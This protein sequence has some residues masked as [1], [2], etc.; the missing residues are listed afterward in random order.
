[1][2][3]ARHILD[4]YSLLAQPVPEVSSFFFHN[5]VAIQLHLHVVVFEDFDAEEVVQFILS[6]WWHARPISY[7]SARSSMV[8]YVAHSFLDFHRW[9]FVE[10]RRLESYS[11]HKSPTQFERRFA[12]NDL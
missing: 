11:T 7:T 3:K 1:M 9:M 10:R 5:L 4:L 8:F 12:L 6:S 2:A